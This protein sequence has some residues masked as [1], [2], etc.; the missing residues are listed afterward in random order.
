[1]GRVEELRL[2]GNYVIQNEVFQALRFVVDRQKAALLTS[3]SKKIWRC[4]IGKQALRHLSF[5]LGQSRP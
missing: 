4:A 5:L 2:T 3:R 1:M